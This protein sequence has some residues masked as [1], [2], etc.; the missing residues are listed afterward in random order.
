MRGAFFGDIIK[1]T[2]SIRN[3][4]PVYF[5]SKAPRDARLAL[6][7]AVGLETFDAALTAV[8]YVAV[9]GLDLA[10]TENGS[11]FSIRDDMGFLAIPVPE[12]P[13]D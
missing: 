11:D 6:R 8:A 1:Q 9:T 5:R 10:L 13:A 7:A 12:I 3:T 2:Q 4:K